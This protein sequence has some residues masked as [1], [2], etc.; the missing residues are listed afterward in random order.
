MAFYSSVN[1][2]V[3]ILGLDTFEKKFPKKELINKVIPSNP[4]SDDK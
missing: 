2:I 3:E 4:S 1:I